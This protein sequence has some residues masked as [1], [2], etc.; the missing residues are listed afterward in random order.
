MF[1]PCLIIL[2]APSGAGKT[3][4]AKQLV[5]KRADIALTISHTTRPQ[6]P[7]EEHDVDYSFVN[8]MEF[9]TM[10]A[11]GCFIEHA[12][13][14]GNRYGT[15]Y[16]TIKT[17]FSQNKHVILEIDWQGARAV[18]RKFSNV[19][20]I[21]VMPPTLAVLEERLKARR[22]DAEETIKERMRA[23]RDEINHKK[24]YDYVIVNADF[25]NA[26][27]EFD[28]I[29]SDHLETLALEPSEF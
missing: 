16:E 7:S 29:V 15:S 13:V 20:S 12:M 11:D 23:A 3:S 24:E 9:E 19:R 8:K 28:A 27:Q 17:L 26:F 14:F 5:S 2:S 6:R 21:F 4:L 10:V 18:R 22:Q 1:L 25:D